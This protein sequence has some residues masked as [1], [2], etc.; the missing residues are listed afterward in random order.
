MSYFETKSGIGILCHGQ[1]AMMTGEAANEMGIKALALGPE[2]NSPASYAIPVISGD[3]NNPSAQINFSYKVEAFVLDTD[4]VKTETLKG[5]YDEG[6]P[7]IPNPYVIH[8]INNRIRQKEWLE[9]AGVPL[10]PW[11]PVLSRA[12]LDDAFKHL[13][14]DVI[15][16]IAEGGFDGRGNI[17]ANSSETLNA[18]WDKLKGQELVMEKRLKIEKEVAMMAVRDAHFNRAFYPLVE[19][20]HKDGMLEYAFCPALVDPRVEKEARKIANTILDTFEGPALLGI[21]Y[22]K[23]KDGELVANEVAGRP[24]NTGHHTIEACTTSQFANLVRVAVGLPLGPVDLL[25]PDETVLMHN[26]NAGTLES[27]GEAEHQAFRNHNGFLH[28]YEKS[29]RPKRKRGHGTFF[30]PNRRSVMGAAK[31]AIAE[32][33]FY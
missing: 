24:H 5:M 13:G 18:A 23:T 17:D 25:N 10:A 4:H 26:L 20:F 33:N 21:E 16:K 31:Q 19:S 12:E 27:A 32:I 7:I 6:F 9:N 15:V 2:E 29:P 22:I 30:G 3:F 8:A 28:W 11:K 1:L 14:G